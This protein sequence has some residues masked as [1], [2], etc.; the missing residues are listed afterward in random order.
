MISDFDSRC[1]GYFTAQLDLHLYHE[2]KGYR[3]EGD[4]ST[5]EPQDLTQIESD[6]LPAPGAM[7]RGTLDDWEPDGVE[8]F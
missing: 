3:S 7:R 1:D 6:P 8:E 5:W 4:Y 2:C